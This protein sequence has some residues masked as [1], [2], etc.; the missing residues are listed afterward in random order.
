MVLL[1][2]KLD[3]NAKIHKQDALWSSLST[4]ISMDVRHDEQK[5]LVLELDHNAPEKVRAYRPLSLELWDRILNRSTS[6]MSVCISVCYHTRMSALLIVFL[7][8]PLHRVEF[9]TISYCTLLARR[10]GVLG[11]LYVFYLIESSCY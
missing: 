7:S 11:C 3:L 5:V 8:T 4:N 1:A 2:L 6:S 10:S 9:K